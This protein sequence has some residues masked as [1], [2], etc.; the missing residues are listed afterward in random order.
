MKKKIC[1]LMICLLAVGLLAGCGGS[2]DPYADYELKDYIK[3]G[4]YKGDVY[5]RQVLP[6]WYTTVEPMW[7]L[8]EP[9]RR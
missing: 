8:P 6:R 7:E 4:K 5:K 3:A 1:L 2:D 9:E